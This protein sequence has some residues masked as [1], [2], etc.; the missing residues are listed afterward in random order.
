MGLDSANIGILIT[1]ITLLLTTVVGLLGTYLKIRQDSRDAE[2]KRDE[3]RRLDKNEI[4]DSTRNATKVALKTEMR[5]KRVQQKQHEG[6][7]RIDHKIDH[8]ILRSEQAFTEANNFNAKLANTR[9]DLNR[10]TERVGALESK[11]DILMNLVAR[12]EKQLSRRR[13]GGHPPGSGERR[14]R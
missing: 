1:Q 6:L 3:E 7:E 9:E 13:D 10:S 12:I 8:S 11:M 2:S 14:G 4:L 5:T